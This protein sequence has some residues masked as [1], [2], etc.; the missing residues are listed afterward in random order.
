MTKVGPRWI[1]L[2]ACVLCAVGCGQSGSNPPIL[3]EV[4]F[5]VGLQNTVAPVTFTASV[6]TGEIV[7]TFP[8]GLAFTT[9]GPF[10]IFLEGASM[11]YG[12][13]FARAMDSGDI[14]VQE[15]IV[16]GAAAGGGGQVTAKAFTTSTDPVSVVL[17]VGA[18]TPTMPVAPNPEVRFDVCVPTAGQSSCYTVG[19]SGTAGLGFNGSLGDAFFTHITVGFT[20]SIYFLEGA[21]DT[22]NGVFRAGTAGDVL[23]V[24]LFINGELKETESGTGDVILRQDL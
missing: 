6:F 14:T 10:S 18:P 16:P 9:G 1:L 23:L 4:Q 2:V 13:T 24:Q 15:T 21:R 8:P 5:L 12:G 20:P 19:N 22:V 7:H 3:P 11:P 17:P